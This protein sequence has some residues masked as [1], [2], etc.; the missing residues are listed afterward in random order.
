M[1]MFEGAMANRPFPLR[2]HSMPTPQAPI[3]APAEL[4]ASVCVCLLSDR[5]D[6][7]E[8]RLAFFQLVTERHAKNHIK[9][10]GNG[11]A[12][13]WQQCP[14]PVCREAKRILEKAKAPEVVIPAISFDVARRKRIM[15]QGRPDG[16]HVSLGEKQL[17][18]PVAAP[19]IVRP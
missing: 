2:T 14:N 4:L 12:V 18:Q 9:P 6:E 10:W 15:F 7:T 16:L 11:D 8:L 13:D 17:V 19:L 5:A 1:K 3:A